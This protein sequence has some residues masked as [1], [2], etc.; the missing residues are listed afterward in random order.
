MCQKY[1]DLLYASKIIDTKFAFPKAYDVTLSLHNFPILMV[2]K[3][4]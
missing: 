3:Q 1:S 4:E 2:Y